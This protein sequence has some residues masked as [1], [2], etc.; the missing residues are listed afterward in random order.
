MTSYDGE[1]LLVGS[2]TINELR[3]RFVG[4]NVRTSRIMTNSE[5]EEYVG[6]AHIGWH[7]G[8]DHGGEGIVVDFIEASI[9]YR[10]VIMIRVDWG[11][12]WMIDALT[13]IQVV[14]D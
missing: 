5:F 1:R 11:Y 10:T 6:S 13:T 14:T 12:E 9:G 3:H 2:R 4:K 7:P 8:F